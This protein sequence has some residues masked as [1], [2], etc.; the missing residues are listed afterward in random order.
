M[1][2]HD[3]NVTVKYSSGKRNQV[4]FVSRHTVKGTSYKNRNK[5]RTAYEHRHAQRN[6]MST[7]PVCSRKSV[8]QN[9][10]NSLFANNWQNMCRYLS[11]RYN[12]VHLPKTQKAA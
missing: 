10:L 4:D 3:Y 2:I 1:K 5:G 8:T 12:T 11:F 7:H 9:N 6:V